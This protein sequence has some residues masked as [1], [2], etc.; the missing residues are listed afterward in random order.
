MEQ[1]VGHPPLSQIDQSFGVLM[2]CHRR[3]EWF[4]LMI[5]R[6]GREAPT[7]IDE[8]HRR[9]LRVALEYFDGAVLLHLEDEEVSLFPRLRRSE[10]G[11][12]NVDAKTILARLQRDHDLARSLHAH[13]DCLGREWLDDG[14]L[15]PG[16]REQFNGQV[17]ALAQLYGQHFEVE[18]AQLYPL[19]HS[20]LSRQEVC[21]MAD[22]IAARRS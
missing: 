13:V 21:D 6:V 19:A 1:T 14:Q 18:D 2:D 7:P 3:I 4:M 8:E 9:A 15:S 20:V 5:A 17:R 10:W 12:G 11:S 22:E 16:Q